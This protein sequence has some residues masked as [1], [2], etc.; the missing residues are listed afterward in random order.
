[1]SK[2]FEG[3]PSRDSVISS[4]MGSQIDDTLH[5]DFSLVSITTVGSQD[6]FFRSRDHA[7]LTFKRMNRYLEDEVLCDVTLIAGNDGK[8]YGINLWIID[9]ISVIVNMEVLV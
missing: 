9:Y 1:M 2:S 4:R 8:R 3:S 7:E 6:E 5:R